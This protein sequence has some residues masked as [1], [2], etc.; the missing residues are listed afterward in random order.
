MTFTLIFLAA[1]TLSVLLRY[2]LALRH[3]RHIQAHRESVPAD[4]AERID[5]ESHHKAADYTIAKTRLGNLHIAVETFLLL[6]FTLGGGIEAL[7]GLW[8]GLLGAGLWQGAALIMS[9]FALSTLVEIPLGFYRAFGID[10][11]FGFNKMTVALFFADLAKQALLGVALGIPLILGVLW[12]MERMGELWW[13]YVWGAWM[14]FNLLVLAV[15]PTFIAPLFNKFTPL[16]D[17]ALKGR[18]EQLLEK[19]GFHAQGFY[20]MDGSR[21]ST[22]GNAYFSGFGKSRRIVFFDTLLERLAHDEIIAVLAHELG[23]FK[24]RHIVKRIALMAAMS[25][26]GLWLLGWLMGNAWFYTGLGVSTPG[27]ASGLLLFLLTMPVF[28]FLLQPL[29]S[30]Y[31]RRNEFE[32]DRY[33]SQNARAEDLIKALVKLYNDNAATLTPDPLHSAFY[34]SHPPAAIRIAQLQKFSAENKTANR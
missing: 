4:F 29:M 19:C 17:S 14:G 16:E 10:A 1:L 2:W 24:H 21:R 5:V 9:V 13:L 32:A 25:L 34:D 33:A 28:T 20:V 18:I 31:S 23:H 8:Q 27:T 22:H 30:F 11:R 15:Y 6:A 3:T 7:N 12:L 26:A